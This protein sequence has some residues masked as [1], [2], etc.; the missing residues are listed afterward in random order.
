MFVC[1][2]C[3]NPGRGFVL[4]G[5]IGGDA[6]EKLI[7]TYVDSLGQQINDTVFLKK[8]AFRFC[9]AINEPTQV[10]LT[11]GQEL[12]SMEDKHYVRLWLEPVAMQYKATGQD[13]KNYVMTGS[14][15][16]NDAVELEK[17]QG[18]LLKQ[19]QALNKDYYEPGSNRDS[20]KALMEPWQKE[21]R[22]INMEFINAHP[23]SYLAPSLLTGYISD[24]TLAELESHYNR[25]TEAVKQSAGG[26]EIA[27]E[28]EN[29]HG[30]SPG[31][32]AY[33]FTATDINGKPF[34]L[35]DL[36]GK[37]VLLDF[38]ASWCAPCR[39]SNPHLKVVYAKYKN[40][41]FDVVCVSDDDSNPDKWREAVKKDGIGA[42]HHVLRGLKVSKDH[43]F[44]RSNDISDRFG[45]HTLPTKILIDREGM[46]VGRYGGGG[47]TEEDMDKQLKKIFGK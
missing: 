14:V 4:D 28:I 41:G 5:H 37:Y 1:A 20:I 47:G 46:V 22:Q 7:L 31:Y 43:H 42:F 24:M 29:L 12:R 6:P 19:I 45:I 15:T 39:A 26:Q 35:A 23:E 17:R 3:T 10:F 13:L 40:Q 34:N 44:D 16:N 38:W 33:M 18:P 2:A 9:G 8:G 21:Y 36:R 30:G 32:P 25:W 11:T 27:K